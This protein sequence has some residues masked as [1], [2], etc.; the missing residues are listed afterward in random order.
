MKFSIKRKDI[1]SEDENS[2]QQKINQTLS[3]N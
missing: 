2:M 1:G 3:K